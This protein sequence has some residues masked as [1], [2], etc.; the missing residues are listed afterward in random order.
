MARRKF[1]PGRMKGAKPKRAPE[2]GLLPGVAP[3][4]PEIRPITVSELAWL[5]DG[6]LRA[7]LPRTIRIVGE[8]SNFTDR[9]HWYFNLKDAESVVSCI[10]FATAA[11]KA[12]F[13]PTGGQQVVA[14]GRVE[15]YAKQGRTQ[16]YVESMDLVG[17]GALEARLRALVEELR[18]L[19][20]L[21]P[22]RKRQLPR[23]PRRVAVVT[24]RTGAALQDVIDTFR[25]RCP[26]VELALIDVRVQGEAAAPEIAQA[27]DWISA[28]HA[29]LGIDAL[30]VTRGG[31]SIED[32]WAFNERVVA[33][34]IVR[35]AVPVVAAIGHETD[36]TVAELVADERAATP[37]QA[38]MR[39]SPD[40]SEL[41]RQHDAAARR[42]DEAA[43]SLLL[44]EMRS[45]MHT[46]RTLL[47]AVRHRAASERS[48]LER[49]AGRLARRRPEAVYAMRRAR[50]QQARDAL[51]DAVQRRIAAA[52]TAPLRY[53]LT[54]ASADC[55]DRARLRLV[56]AQREL[57]IVGPSAVLRRGYSITSVAGGMVVR[58]ALDV[59]PGDRLTTRLADGSIASVVEGAAG[60][61]APRPSVDRSSLPP[62]PPD[63]PTPRRPARKPPADALQMDLFGE[64]GYRRSP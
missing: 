12:G 53:R 54:R 50:L 16:F 42:L 46:R 45:V 62:R 39:L 58:A 55:V 10:M 22:A 23:F 18:A 28:H 48:R 26:A 35:C 8:I 38:A 57:A 33:Q 13:T 5:I 6:A 51:G 24:S 64:A 15:Y 40:R 11:R 56:Q 32:L 4:T 52:R 7:G 21:D 20:W 27:I 1:D 34:A 37:T 44:D 41:Q 49:L 2:P 9:T 29:A 14:S 30:I 36:V 25:R 60:G 43:R 31:G 47:A 61:S 19:G 17:A 59:A 3:P 63:R